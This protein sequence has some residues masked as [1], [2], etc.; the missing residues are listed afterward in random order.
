M[1]SLPMSMTDSMA[2]CKYLS[3]A[4]LDLKSVM[5]AS[6]DAAFSSLRNLRYSSSL[7][8]FSLISASIWESPP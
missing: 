2:S 1:I 3:A 5:K 7:D 6:R 4:P 8:S